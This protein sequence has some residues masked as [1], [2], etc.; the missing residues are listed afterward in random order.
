MQLMERGYK[1]VNLFIHRILRNS[2]VFMRT[3]VPNYEVNLLETPSG[4]SSTKS[5]STQ[6]VIITFDRV[7]A[8]LHCLRMS[9]NF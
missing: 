5:I 2:L 6:V 4:E 9:H 3:L 7:Y 1:T 8:I